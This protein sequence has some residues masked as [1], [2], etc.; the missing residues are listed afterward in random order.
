MIHETAIINSGARLGKDVVVGP[1]T[2]IEADVTI[3]DGT[4]IG[5]NVSIR[6][7]TSIGPRCH[8]HAGSVLGGIPQDVGFKGERSF[9]T[10]G[11]NC[12]IREGVTINRGTKADSVTEIGD[13]CFLMAFSHCAH[14]VKL[15][16]G[17]IMANGALLAGYVEIGDQVVISGNCILHQFVRVGRLVML[18]G[19]CAVTKDVPPFCMLKPLEINKI[20]GL[21]T[22]G[23]RRSN[24]TARDQQEIKEGFKLLF[25]SGLNVSKALEKIKATY[26]SGPASEFS[27]FI[28]QSK[29]G[30]CRM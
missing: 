17:V 14:N 30:I 2:T 4:V 29:R 25:R 1:F 20:V 24:L 9:V 26:P 3:G 27:T 10:I 7:Y 18:G 23:L 15:G 5:P 28:E 13:G 22:V 6:P 16:R 19:G 21:N 11:A 8:V 12:Q